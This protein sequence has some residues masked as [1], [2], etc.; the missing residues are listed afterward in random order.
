[1][2]WHISIHITIKYSCS[3]KKRLKI[4]FPPPGKIKSKNKKKN[5][6]H[7]IYIFK[8]V[9]RL[10]NVRKLC[11]TNW[12]SSLTRCV[13]KP[14]RAAGNRSTR[15]ALN[16]PDTPWHP[17]PRQAVVPRPNLLATTFVV[18]P[19]TVPATF[20]FPP[21]STSSGWWWWRWRWWCWCCLQLSNSFLFSYLYA[22][23]TIDEYWKWDIEKILYFFLFYNL[24]Y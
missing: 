12:I 1:M 3:I 24:I 23:W 18:H 11:A 6:T 19:T 21:R 9:C 7:Y 4:Q 22:R 8:F 20:L 17:H 14:P 10:P 2:P 13:W 15:P 5:Y 16:T